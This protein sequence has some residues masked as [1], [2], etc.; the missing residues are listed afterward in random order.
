MTS[1]VDPTD[2]GQSVTFTANVSATAPATGTP[3]GL[4]IFYD[5]TTAIDT[6]TLVDGSATYSTSALAAGGHAITIRY[7]GDAEF[8]GG[9][10]TAIT[11]TVDQASTTTAVTPSDNPSVYG[12]SETFTATVSSVSPGSGTPAGQLTFYD[13]TMAVDTENL[14]N[15]TAS[16]TTSSLTLGGHTITAQYLGSTDFIAS[17]STA[18]TQTVSQDGSKTFLSASA[19]PTSLGQSVTFSVTVIAATPGSGTP[20]GSVTFYDGAT[21]IDSET[22]ANGKAGFTTSSLAMGS[23]TISAVYGGDTD[24]TGSS[25][26]TVAEIVKQDGATTAVTSSTNPTVHGQS[27]TFTATV[28][29][30]PPA[31][32]TPSGTVTFYDGTTLV[33]TETLVGGIAT[34]TTSSLAVG[35]HAITVQYAGDANFTSSTSAVL[36]QTVNPAALSSIALTP[37]DPSISE[38]LTEQFTA[39]GTYTDGSVVNLTS[40]ASWTSSNLAVAT[41][42]SD[43]L[44]TAVG[45]GVTTIDATVDRVTG[46]T[47]LTGTLVPTLTLTLDRPAVSDA[48]GAGAATATVTRSGGLGTVLV[49]TLAS[50]DVSAATVPLTVTI[51]AGQ[52]SATFPVNAVD[53]GLVDGDQTPILTAS[54]A[55]FVP[56]TASLTVTETDVRTLTLVLNTTT[57][58]E[59]GSVTGQVTRNWITNAPLAVTF[60]ASTDGRMTLPVVVIGANQSSAAFT[61]DTIDSSEPEKDETFSLTAASGGFVSGTASLTITDHHNLPTLTLTPSTSQVVEN[62]AGL[63]F[64]VYRA[65]AVDTPLTVKLSTSDSD[66]AVPATSTVVIP[67]YAASATFVV[68][69]VQNHVAEGNQTVTITA[70]GAYASCGCTILFGTGTASLLVINS[71]APALQLASNQTSALRA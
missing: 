66:L 12:E 28:T 61:V 35:G 31:T 19:N 15:G 59:G 64:T 7:T 42:N 25:S 23:H 16:Y 63:T 36:N 53:D 3:T 20:T 67:A 57:V 17:T 68:N 60:S 27:V 41:I 33:D 6:E 51:P 46:T 21:A 47:T 22:L 71:D 13:G 14:V 37:A 10:S 1:S 44:A 24:F 69:P 18:F 39:T 62:G 29:A 50:N 32:G 5:G 52:A 54:A 49:V 65:V 11:Q 2:F 34:Y 9:T 55:G 70:N 45:T 4:V 48:A 30:T 43:G 58:E 40:S 8:V 26:P 56:G 38:G